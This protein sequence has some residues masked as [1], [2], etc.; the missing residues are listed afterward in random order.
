MG[1]TVL[2]ETKDGKCYMT[3][4]RPEKFNALNLQLVMELISALKKPLFPSW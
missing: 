3:L 2:Y 4:N 1:S